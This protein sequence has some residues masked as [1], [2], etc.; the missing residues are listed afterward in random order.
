MIALT[1]VLARDEPSIMI[2]CCCPGFCA[3]DMSSHRGTRS[4]EHG[5][6]TPTYLAL[7]PTGSTRP[8]GKFFLDEKEIT[9]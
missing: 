5:A 3:T 8:T 4:A 1:K 6:R 9:W 7:Y 2:N